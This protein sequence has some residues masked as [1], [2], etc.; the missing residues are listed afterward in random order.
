MHSRGTLRR[1]LSGLT[2]LI[3]H[4]RAKLL[5]IV[6]LVEAFDHHETLLCDIC[7]NYCSSVQFIMP[8]V[9]LPL[10]VLES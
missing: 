2:A 1:L 6:T 9:Q 8:R 10:S 4:R 7:N 3:D 5:E